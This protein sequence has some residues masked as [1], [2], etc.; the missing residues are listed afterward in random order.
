MRLHKAIHCIDKRLDVGQMNGEF[1]SLNYLSNKFSILC[2]IEFTIVQRLST[3]F[4]N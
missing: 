3:F 1:A 2:F 4:L